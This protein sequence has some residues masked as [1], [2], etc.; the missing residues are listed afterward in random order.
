MHR[1]PSFHRNSSTT[2][3]L[4]AR[5]QLSEILSRHYT[6]A[7]AQE[8]R[9]K[10]ERDAEGRSVKESGRERKMPSSKGNPTDPELR[11]QVKEE[12]KAEEKGMVDLVVSHSVPSLVAMM[13]A[14]CL[15]TI[16]LVYV[17]CLSLPVFT[18][19]FIPHFSHYVFPHF[20]QKK[21]P[22]RNLL[23][24]PPSLPHLKAMNRTY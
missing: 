8:S 4:T 16:Y 12:V 21:D 14:I 3:V 2:G 5:E 10:S 13:K 22:E 15:S 24:A 23:A 18:F 7:V 20:K 1:F 11:E 9:R 17:P 19:L 6:A